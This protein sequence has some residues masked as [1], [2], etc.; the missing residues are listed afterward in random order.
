MPEIRFDFFQ[1]ITIAAIINS[2]IFSVLLL[3]KKENQAANYFLSL[4]LF[5]VGYSLATQLCIDLGVYNYY[6]WLHWLPAKLSYFIGPALY[7]YVKAL[8]TQPFVFKR[9]YLWHFAWLILEY[10]HSIY[11]LQLGRGNPYPR[12]HNFTEALD[13]YALFPLLVFAFLSYRL[14]KDYR[15]DLK[16]QYSS[17]ESLTLDWLHQLIVLVAVLLGTAVVIYI[18]DFRIFYDYDMEFFEGTLLQ[19]DSILTFLFIVLIYWLSIGGLRQSQLNLNRMVLVPVDKANQKDYSGTIDRLVQT[20]EQRQLFLDPALSISKLAQ[21]TGLA[22]REISN[23]L[24]QQLKKNFYAFVNE[25]RVEEVKKRLLDTQYAHLKILSIA[26]DAGF[27][28]KATFNRIFKEYTSESPK[29]YRSA[30]KAH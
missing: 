1:V 25:F 26:F 28:S 13:A 3:W 29:S 6:P 18:V 19:Y 8:T 12:L 20:M 21:Q 9:A 16:D 15:R 14:I 30:N 23:A 7:F 4:L 2:L 5:S 24:N 27:N 22:E 11:H 17:T 10:P